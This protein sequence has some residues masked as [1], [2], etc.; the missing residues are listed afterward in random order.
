MHGHGTFVYRP[1]FAIETFGSP[2]G[3]ADALKAMG[4]SHAWLRV[5]NKN[6]AWHPEANMAL[7]EALRAGGINVGVWG[8]NDGNDVDLDID[9]SWDDIPAESL[10]VVGNRSAVGEQYV[11][12]QPQVDSGPYLDDRS[13]IAQADT[14]TPIA[15]QK[16]LTDIS[17]TV[18][19]VDKPSLRTTVR[20]VSSSSTISTLPALRPQTLRSTPA[21]RSR[22]TGFTR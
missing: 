11:E 19:S 6:G 9:N 4:M 10:A 17:D 20:E 22:S 7:A 8:W 18:E 21:R 1:D 5:H 3:V 13:E 14:R 2:E 12:L 16:L 15:T